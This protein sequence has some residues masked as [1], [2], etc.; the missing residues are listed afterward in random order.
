M[1]TWHAANVPSGGAADSLTGW[2][3]CKRDRKLGRVR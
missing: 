2:G 1:E 3:L